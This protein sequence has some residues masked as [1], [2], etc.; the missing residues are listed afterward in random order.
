MS[1][2]LKRAFDKPQPTDGHRVLVDRLWPRGV[3]K[4]ALKLDQWLK[5]IAP[6]HELRQAFHQGELSW[7]EFRRV[8]LASLKAHRDSLRELARHSRQE[9]VT[10]I[11]SAKD[12]ARN[13]A[14]VVA[15]YLKMLGG[16]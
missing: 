6:S 4:E 10:L 15:Q 13:N 9:P 7:G 16:G 11:Y 1:I 2:Q 5:D 8:Y 3:S 12:S 14:R